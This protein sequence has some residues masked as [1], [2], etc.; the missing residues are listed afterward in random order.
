MWSTAVFRI[1]SERHIEGLA[2]PLDRTIPQVAQGPRDPA[3]GSPRGTALP[4]FHSLFQN[5]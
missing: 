3:K 1:E 4:P 5:D 2:G